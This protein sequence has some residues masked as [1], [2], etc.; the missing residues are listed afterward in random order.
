[1]RFANIFVGPV[2]QTLFQ[3]L[4]VNNFYD[5]VEQ[6]GFRSA[7]RLTSVIRGFSCTSILAQKPARAAIQKAVRTAKISA[8]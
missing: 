1:M 4:V 8:W 2:K 5:S 3:A 7:K 6:I